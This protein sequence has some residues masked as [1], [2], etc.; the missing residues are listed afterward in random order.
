M[1]PYKARP[2]LPARCQFLKP[3]ANTEN[4]SPAPMETEEAVP[5]GTHPISLGGPFLTS[6]AFSLEDEGGWDCL[7]LQEQCQPQP[8]RFHLFLRP[9]RTIPSQLAGPT[10]TWARCAQTKSSTS[11]FCP[12]H[13][14]R[15]TSTTSYLP[16]YGAVTFK[17]S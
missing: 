14:P 9:H 12:S 3:C 6:G 17:K 5:S 13:A 1:L 8:Q 4:N 7:S 16:S 11:L 10:F 2:A 15:T